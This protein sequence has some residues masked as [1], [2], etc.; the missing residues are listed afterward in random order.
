VSV[1]AG[2]S[3][4]PSAAA[5][6]VVHAGAATTRAA[7]SARTTA[8]GARVAEA[9]ALYVENEAESVAKL[10]AVNPQAV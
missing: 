8:T 1:G 9:D 4:Q 2:R 3:F 10:D 5:V 7:L 6:Q